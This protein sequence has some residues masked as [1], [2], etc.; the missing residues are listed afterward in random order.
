[1]RF[2]KVFD[3]LP[4]HVQQLA[5]KAFR[6]WLEDPFRP[7]LRFKRVLQAPPVYSVRIGIEWR[8]LGVR[9][10]NEM[11]WFWIG[12]HGDYDKLLSQM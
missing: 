9:D 1:M 11:T 2:R 4:A 3:R 8:A 6:M 10:G 12:S 5:G 7:S